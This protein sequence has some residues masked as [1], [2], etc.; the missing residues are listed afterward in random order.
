MQEV[1]EVEQH[2]NPEEEPC[3][4]TSWLKASKWQQEREEEEFPSHT[5]LVGRD[6]H[7]AVEGCKFKT[8]TW[9]T[10]FKA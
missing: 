7:L 2:S 5:T 6:R 10:R 8:Q 4:T 9:Q 3:L 1:Q